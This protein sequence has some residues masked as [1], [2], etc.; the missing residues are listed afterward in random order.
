MPNES[1]GGISVSIAVGLQDLEAQFQQAQ[2][3]ADAAGKAMAS[4]F[5]SSAGS[6]TDLGN[7][8]ADTSGKVASLSS[9]LS[10]AAN[11][12]TNAGI[13]MSTLSAGIIG[14][15]VEAL[16][17]AGKFE[18][19]D[20]SFT[21]LLGS[22]AAAKDMINQLV[23]F[24]ISTPFEIK[25]L[26]P[27]AQKLM[28]MG[29]AAQDVIPM[30]R[31]LGD[32]V[33]GLGKG[34]DS[35]NSLTL[36]FGEMESKGVVQ[37]RQLNMLAIQGIPAIKLLADAYGESTEQI[38]SQI[39]KKLIPASEAIPI[40]LAGINQ[41]FGGMMEAQSQTLLGMWSNLE[42]ATTKTM[43]AIGQAILPLFKSI[44][45]EAFSVLSGIQ[46]LAEMFAMLPVPVQEVAVGIAAVVA[47]MGP[48]LLGLGAL[49]FALKSLV[50]L[51]VAIE[52]LATAMG[53]MT[54][55]TTAAATAQQAQAVA[56]GEVAVA[57]GAA[58]IATGEASVAN[59]AV[60][61]SAGAATFG[62]AALDTAVK[63]ASLAF[64]AL[65]GYKVGEWLY[66][67]VPAAKAFGDAIGDAVN[68]NVFMGAALQALADKFAHVKEATDQE[69]N[70]AFLLSQ[71]LGE[72]GIVIPRGTMS[73]DEWS[74]ALG[75]AA[76]A[77]Q[78][79][80]KEVIEG[81]AG[82][83]KLQEQYGALEDSLDK[84]QNVLAAAARGLQ[85]GTVSAGEYQM[86]VKAVD[87]AQKKLNA[88][89]KDYEFTLGGLTEA[90]NKNQNTID[91][92]T[93][94]IAQLLAVQDRTVA[95]ENILDK[96]LADRWSLIQKNI[97]AI[98]SQMGAEDAE[99]VAAERLIKSS[100]ELASQQRTI[101]ISVGLAK[102]ALDELTASDD[103]S[104]GHQQAVTAAINQ[105]ATALK[106]S[107]ASLDTMITV[108]V[109]GVGVIET[110]GQALQHA[111]DGLVAVNSAA[112]VV[113]EA[114]DAATGR[115]NGMTTALRGIVDGATDT[116][117]V[118]RILPPVAAEAKR[119]FDQMGYGAGNSAG[120]VAGLTAEM[121]RTVAAAGQAVLA[122]NNL[123]TS[124]NHVGEATADALAV[125]KAWDSGLASTVDNTSKLANSVSKVAG[126]LHNMATKADE[127]GTA[128]FDADKSFK[129]TTGSVNALSVGVA[130]LAMQ[131]SGLTAFAG[132]GG[133]INQNQNPGDLQHQLY[134]AKQAAG[135]PASQ[136]TSFVTAMSGPLKGQSF[137]T[138]DDLTKALDDLKTNAAAATT[139]T[140]NLADVT[141]TTTAS[142]TQYVDGVGN[143]YDSYQ[144]M[145]DAI[146]ANPALGG[147]T[148][149][150]QALS[151]T[152]SAAMNANQNAS[153][154]QQQFV[155][156]LG[157]VY[158]SYQALTDAIKN[159]P[160]LGGPAN[161]LGPEL[162]TGQPSSM[163]QAMTDALNKM[164]T[165]VFSGEGPELAGGQPST[166]SQA[167]TDALKQM[168][169]PVFSADTPGYMNNSGAPTSTPFGSFT[170]TS[171][172]VYKNDG[173]M[174][175]I[176]IHMSYPQFNNQQ[177]ADQIM[178]QIVT[179]LRTVAGQK[180]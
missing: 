34:A 47:A 83:L 102:T 145:I 27:N 40:L 17:T 69:A 151:S 49:S 12:L 63:G 10:T 141:K 111:K 119:Q 136:P 179:Q 110:V 36:A 167:M 139:A 126:E 155:D 95:Q 89:S 51:P 52:A 46:N 175:P 88:G 18:Q 9:N 57:E 96:A 92:Y 50:E 86:A 99:S 122:N 26:V 166:M 6:L 130:F 101:A 124:I 31:T 87:D 121:N 33:S 4:A 41:K 76:A 19:W 133:I 35:L 131:L 59:V 81:N 176:T 82:L 60:A 85:D 22:A 114:M 20:V 170:G 62:F 48:L 120:L 16:T 75:R 147:L 123:T 153:A 108:M 159:N 67:N 106:N 152:A 74:Q 42:D 15:G 97:D 56:A 90:Y 64:A 134:L 43:N 58:A 3:M 156:G 28:A 164:S 162:A 143:V 8:A 66:E 94:S 115:F 80:S 148:S 45:Q 65:I 93:R 140:Q 171:G 5:N 30:L 118:I 160:L 53:L 78:G 2:Q 158:D 180:L 11:G 84:A 117:N 138:I 172:T 109:N 144:K 77:H 54:G 71:K 129:A 32:A 105:Y 116:I 1:I 23:D 70:S 103:K 25:D 142:L 146:N 163:S 72:L 100:S 157:N 91:T 37:L 174:Q 127:A 161:S 135:D 169:T 38:T 104:V 132:S 79:L 154:A 29:F 107:G 39:S 112:V 150:I 165:P 125:E 178:K 73:L 21:R 7:A 61:E 98:K 55:A 44:E 128:A 177:Q 68:Q 137:N 168:A 13:V 24:A 173:S 113:P 14:L 149:S